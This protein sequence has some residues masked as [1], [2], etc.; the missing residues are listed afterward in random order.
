MDEL[1]ELER[2]AE[3]IGTLAAGFGLESGGIQFE[4]CPADIIYTFGAY[5][6]P[7]RFAHWSFGKQFYRLKT[8]YDYNLSRI[9]EL[10]I[11][12]DPCQAFLLEGNSLV[13]NKLVMAHVLAHS[14]FFRHNWHFRFTDRKNILEVMALHAARMREYEAAHGR[15]EVEIFLDACLALQ[16]HINPYPW[17]ARTKEEESKS[18]P[19]PTGYDD[20]WVLDRRETKGPAPAASRKNPPRPEKDL[21]GFVMENG[22]QLEDWQRDIIAMIREEMRYFWPQIET[23]IMNEGWA[24]FW[25]T[26]ILREL[27]LPEAEAV[28]YAKLQGQLLQPSFMVLNPYLVGVRIFEDIEKR[29]DEAPEAGHG[30]EKL[31]EVR[32]IESDMSFLRNYLTKDLVSEL[33]LYLYKRVGSSWVVT[34]KKWEKV[35]DTLVQSLNNGGFPYIEVLD[36]DYGHRGE[37]YLKHLFEGRPLDVLYV[38]RTLPYV[39]LLWGRP[40][41]L[42]TVADGKTTLFSYDGKKN[43]RQVIGEG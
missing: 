31:F 41:H 19:P 1:L 23:K 14:D 25:H 22:Y 15:R 17:L 11:N 8:Q 29:W 6:M 34:E 24:T 18:E 36:G 42:E 37:L 12:S 39:Y 16:E 7:T 2:A 10:V 33:D 35:R 5:G 40:V 27:D 21:L 43:S 32:E 4:L 26:R 30:R 3:E 9:Y 38:E 20:L 13:Q 28:E